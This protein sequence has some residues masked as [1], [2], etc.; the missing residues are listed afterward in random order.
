MPD[1][2]TLLWRTKTK[3]RTGRPPKLTLDAVV[4]R[5][6]ED[7][8]DA[9]LEGVTMA[10]LAGG[11]GVGTMTL[12]SYV[13][14]RE[15]LIDLMVDDVSARRALPGPGEERPESWRDQVLLYAGRT[16]AMYAEHPWLAQVSQIRP[17]PGP[18]LMAEREYVLSTMAGLGLPAA[19]MNAA[20]VTIQLFVTSAAHAA[21]EAELLR[22]A[23]GQTTEDWWQSH[24][25]LWEDYFDVERH[26]TMNELWLA[27]GF[28]DGPDDAY[29]YG[30]NLILDGMAATTPG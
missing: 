25:R 29:A 8:D 10:R 11:L 14:S 30:L 1:V 3:A 13:P 19:R 23:T 7:A 21:A 9:G 12:Y 5:A 26:P 22:R 27:G 15:V 24:A 2:L 20:A 16:R 17:P 28:T 4:E 6:I 18:G